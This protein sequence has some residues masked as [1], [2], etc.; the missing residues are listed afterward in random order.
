MIIVDR[1]GVEVSVATYVEE[2]ITNSWTSGELESM[3]KKIELTARYIGKL[4]NL[5]VEKGVI[6]LCEVAVAVGE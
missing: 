5:L 6:N 4:T 2:C 1:D 3:D